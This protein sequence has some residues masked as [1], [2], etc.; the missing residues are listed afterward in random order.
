MQ[1]LSKDPE[2]APEATSF[3]PMCQR[4]VVCLRNAAK[5]NGPKSWERLGH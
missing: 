4:I 3:D 2:T 5:K 1:S